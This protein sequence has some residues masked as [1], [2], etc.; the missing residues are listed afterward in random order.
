MTSGSIKPKGR[1]A[2]FNLSGKQLKSLSGGSEPFIS[3]SDP[4]RVSA[5]REAASLLLS[6]F[7]GDLLKLKSSV[8]EKWKIKG[9]VK[10]S[11]ILA[12]IPRQK[13]SA[14]ILAVLKM[15]LTRTISG[16][17]PVAVM[18]ASKCP[19]GRCTYCPAGEGTANSYTGFEPAAMRGRQNNY[20]A[21]LQV[22]SRLG[23]YDVLGHVSDKCELIVMGGTFNAQPI[24]YQR[25]FIKRAFEG[26][27]GHESASMEEAIIS[28]QKA[29][30]RVIGVTYETKPDWAKKQ[31]DIDNLLSMAASRVEL[32]VQVL[33]DRIYKKVN[34]GH[35]LADV[36]SA[37]RNLR[38]NSLKVGYHMMP[39]LYQTPAQDIAGFRKLFSDPR[40]RPDMLKI[41]P[42]L[43]L[44]GTKLYGE[45]KAGKFK[46]YDTETAAEV[47]AKVQKDLPPYVRVMR[48]QR[49]IPSNL[50]E[51]G[52]KNSNVRQIAEN[53]MAERGWSC[54]CIRCREVGIARHT[55]GKLPSLSSLS[56]ERLDYG[57]GKGKE[58]FLSFE[59]K[60]SDTLAGFIRLRMP[61]QFP[62]GEITP[63][64]ALIRELHVYG[65]EA[66][67]G[68]GAGTGSAQHLGIGRELLEEA[69]RIAKQEF[70]KDKMII[71]S[72]IGA[73]PY[74][75]KFGYK[76]DGPYVSRKI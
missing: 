67:I 41:Y 15:R 24:S 17:T 37:T 30:H 58:V 34:R 27:N 14:K 57:A 60:K 6:G 72:G 69:Q 36:V 74:Y 33:S 42:V 49:D 62:R 9:M 2:L 25:N 16:V 18:T 12:Q 64:T 68:Y 28:N 70:G 45:F 51:G 59:D 56:L 48:V 76:A 75:A 71:I 29:Q 73:R 19:H 32:G 61:S 11:E 63:E 55:K 31:E 7:S 10:N 65:Q 3:G 44:K 5:S 50:I 52:P 26:F 46:P 54:R 20:D 22:R 43:V 21:L 23:Q 39:G 8:S 4:A 66:A 1:F 53:I 38:D 40:F 35:T 47:V 13:R